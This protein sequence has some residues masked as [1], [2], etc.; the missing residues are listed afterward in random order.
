MY[1]LKFPVYLLMGLPRNRTSEFLPH[2]ELLGRLIGGECS[3]LMYM[4]NF[5]DHLLRDLPRKRPMHV[6]HMWNF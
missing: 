4:L 1:M 5:L 3:E 6:R 2:V